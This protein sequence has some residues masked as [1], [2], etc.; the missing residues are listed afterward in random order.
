MNYLELP[1]KAQPV[2][3]K[4]MSAYLPHIITPKW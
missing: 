3:Q 2:I 4:T 1:V